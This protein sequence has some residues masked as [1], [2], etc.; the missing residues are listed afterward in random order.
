MPRSRRIY[1]FE[2]VKGIGGD[3]GVRAT[4]EM[5]FCTE[6]K[7]GGGMQ[8]KGSHGKRRCLLVWRPNMSLPDT[9]TLSLSYKLY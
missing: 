5:G 7:K 2:R 9:G 4:F 8:K 6:G 1:K 3:K